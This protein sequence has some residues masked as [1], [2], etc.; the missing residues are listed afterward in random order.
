M[1]GRPVY[2]KSRLLAAAL[3]WLFPGFGVMYS[4]GFWKGALVLLGTFI[5]TGV[6]V[7]VAMSNA[8][9]A[10][11]EDIVDFFLW[12]FLAHLVWLLFRMIWAW[13]LA[14]RATRLSR[15]YGG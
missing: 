7:S 14:S 6:A 13:R 11:V 1:P 4:G 3:E 2:P 8:T 12:L 15:M 10:Q 9:G 5:A